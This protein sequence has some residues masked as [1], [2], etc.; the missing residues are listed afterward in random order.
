MYRDDPDYQPRCRPS[1]SVAI[2]EKLL[3]SIDQN[4]T[5]DRNWRN[6]IFAQFPSSLDYRIAREY[7]EKFI[8]ENRRDANLY[9]LAQG[10]RS[11]RYSVPINM[12]DYELQHFAKKTAQEMRQ[13][14]WLYHN[15]D[16]A[17][18]ALWKRAAKMG[19]SPPSPDDPNMTIIGALRRL[20]ADEW[21]LK[22]FR[23]LQARTLE[24]EAI[25]LGMVHK[26]A[27]AYV[28]DD[29][30]NRYREQKKRNRRIL[31]RVVATNEHGQAF[32]LED[33][34]ALGVSNPKN[35]RNELMARIYGFECIADE[36]GHIAVFITVTCPSR[37]HP[38]LSKSCKQNPKF[39]GTLPSQAQQHLCKTWSRVRAQLKRDGV[40]IY[41][42]RVAEPHHDG[43]PHW[44]LLAFLP[45]HQL[46]SL[47]STFMHY[48]LQ[49][50]PDEAGADKHRVK[51]EYIDKAKG[52]A[53]GY[54][55]KYISKNIDGYALDGDTSGLDSESAAE[56]ILAWAS[57]WGI[58][59]FQQFGGAPVTI[60][61]ELRKASGDIPEGKL[62]EA[63]E[64]ADA[65]HWAAFLQVMGGTTPKRKELPIQLAKIESDDK[66]RYGDPIGNKT[67]GVQSGDIILK[68]RIHV[69]RFMILP[70][71]S[72][73]QFNRQSTHGAAIAGIAGAAQPHTQFRNAAPLEFCQ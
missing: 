65:G 39:D 67:I 51:W 57:T 72:P 7:E 2:A 60:W 3:A 30:R 53:I 13:L 28:S 4:D 18:I 6:N 61:R 36:L 24:A 38:R 27:G 9:L 1:L 34:A 31:Q 64:A 35:R 15:D 58:R 19:V 42:F 68:T 70:K 73:C 59:Q 44:H 10:E 71:Q 40:E 12:D 45:A 69:W 52:S 26:R 43:T 50:D 37:M 56:R 41:G 22:Q 54:I 17:V 62:K 16:D 48:A 25:N 5:T 47:Q 46:A 63:F 49:E 23:R 33:L 29:T 14:C 66:G 21:W 32:S 8:F 20:C 11:K 55:A